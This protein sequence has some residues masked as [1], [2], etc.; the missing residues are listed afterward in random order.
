[1]NYEIVQ[2]VCSVISAVAIPGLSMVIF[3][4]SKKRVAAAEA[5]AK[6]N[7]V[8]KEYATEWRELYEKKEKKVGDLDKKVD[9]LRLL[10][11]KDREETITLEKTIAV[12]QAKV[13]ILQTRECIVLACPKRVNTQ[14]NA[15]ET[16]ERPGTEQ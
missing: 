6:E 9:E 16:S 14:T 7:E 10:I 11:F 8:V 15:K 5:A 13:E 12:L 4:D 3:Y 1:M 2:L